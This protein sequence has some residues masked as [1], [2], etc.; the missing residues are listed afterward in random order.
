MSKTPNSFLNTRQGEWLYERVMETKKA[1]S[2]EAAF[3]KIGESKDL[4]GRLC[5]V[6]LIVKLQK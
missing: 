6:V 1:A 4:V 3:E 5:R 2:I